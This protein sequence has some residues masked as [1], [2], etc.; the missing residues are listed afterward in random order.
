M[1]QGISG[2]L[3]ALTA[4]GDAVGLAF[5]I[6]DDMLNETSS[7]ATL[8]KTAGSDRAHGKMTYV[9]VHGLQAA[10]A[11]TK[12]LTQEALAALDALS[13]PQEPLAALARFITERTH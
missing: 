5:Q 6:T 9:A 10:R 3:A 13:H 8:G 2:N 1:R 7:A 12:Q 11:R 4:Y